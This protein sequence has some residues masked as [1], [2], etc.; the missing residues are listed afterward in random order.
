MV[1]GNSNLE[2]LDLP[3]LEFWPQDFD[4]ELLHSIDWLENGAAPGQRPEQQ[5]MQ[6]TTETV[7]ESSTVMQGAAPLQLPTSHVV[8]TMGQM[9]SLG[10]HQQV[11]LAQHMQALQAGIPGLGMVGGSPYVLFLCL[12]ANL[13][14]FEFPF[15]GIRGKDHP[16]NPPRR[17]PWLVA[18][19]SCLATS[20]VPSTC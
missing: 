15:N 7:L 12:S 10:G 1:A 2:S 5:H 14:L 19:A 6:Q 20:Q 11:S 8:P 3:E 9:V 17:P 18:P 16:F 13:Q 4:P